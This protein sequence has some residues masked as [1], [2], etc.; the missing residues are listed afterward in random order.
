[1]SSTG[2]NTFVIA[3]VSGLVL[4][5][6]LSLGSR[7][8]ARPTSAPSGSRRPRLQALPPGLERHGMAAELVA[9]RRHHLELE[10][11]LV[12]GGESG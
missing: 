12:L 8:R 3:S 5:L 7:S 4:R 10:R 9:Q 6:D 11:V 1:M 2:S